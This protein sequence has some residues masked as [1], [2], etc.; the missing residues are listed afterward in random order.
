MVKC[1]I[2]NIEK[3]ASIVE[4]LKYSHK[5]SSKEY[6]KLYSNADVKSMDQKKKMSDMIK[7]KWS[8]EEY[9]K[10]Q[11]DIRNITHKS[12]EFRKKMSEKIKK[13]HEETPNVF[14]GFTNWSKTDKY[15]VWVKS[16]ERKKKIS[17]ASISN[18]KNNTYRNKV[19]NSLKESLS[20][21]VCAKNDEYRK[22]MSETISKLYSTGE[23]KNENNKYKTGYFT[24]KDGEKFFYS[25]S[26]EKSAMEIF[27][28][29]PK[30]SHWTNKHGL[31][32][33]YYFNNLERNYVPDFYVEFQ[34][35]V[36]Y[37]IEM[38]GWETEE[39]RIKEY[40]T[41]KKYNNYKIFYTIN[42]LTH[43]LND[44]D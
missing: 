21:G 24:S 17:D 8:D 16:D 35:G 44:N 23:I 6:K 25:S 12:P 3:K 22:K 39:V 36:S 42:E 33:K 19:I 18:W 27:D 13:I 29:H 7:K 32:I 20:N 41:K 30:I 2:C 11:V 14:S 43:F 5:M 38:K 10:K 26:Y 40:Y 15:K 37:I 4:H 1:L 31:R 28:S 34:N 9:R